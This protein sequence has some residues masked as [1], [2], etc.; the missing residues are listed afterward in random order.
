L[1]LGEGWDFDLLG[2]PFFP[3][4]LEGCSFHSCAPGFRVLI[5]IDEIFMVN[6]FVKLQKC[7]QTHNFIDQGKRLLHS[8]REAK[9]IYTSQALSK[10]AK[11]PLSTTQG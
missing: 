5:L 1:D 3:L 2:F 8:G 9:H 10:Y 6:V 7:P 4:R 11:C